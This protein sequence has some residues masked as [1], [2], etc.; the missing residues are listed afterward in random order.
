MSTT[1]PHRSAQLRVKVL[2]ND[3]LLR[4]F[5]PAEPHSYLQSPYSR[6]HSQDTVD[7]SNFATTISMRHHLL[8]HSFAL[9]QPFSIR[10]HTFI[11]LTWRPFPWCYQYIWSSPPQFYMYHFAIYSFALSRPFFNL[12]QVPIFVFLFWRPFPRHRWCTWPSLPLYCYR[13]FQLSDNPHIYIPL[14]DH[15]DLFS[16]NPV[17]IC[18]LILSTSS[19][20]ISK[21][22][23]VSK[24]VAD[25]I[26]SSHQNPFQL[27][28]DI[29]PS[30]H[31]TFTRFT[32]PVIRFSL[33]CHSSPTW[34]FFNT[35]SLN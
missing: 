7:T 6:D 17:F 13:F 28:L 20:T 18:H 5:L 12:F 9:F 30:Y 8:I 21:N 22:S 19:A 27:V 26:L 15:N 3:C 33:D 32:T 34:H 11:L 1:G 25:L 4:P 31:D 24:P 23:P 29:I 2:R 10:I 35:Y 14:S 16:F